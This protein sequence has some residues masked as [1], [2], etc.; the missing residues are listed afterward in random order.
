MKGSNLGE[1]EEIVLLIVGIA[2]EEAYGLAIMELIKEQA[3]RSTTIGAVH[4]VL[5][6]LEDK[7]LLNSKL[8]GATKERGG[9][10][11]RIFEITATGRRALELS[12][13]LRVNL[14]EQYA[15][16]TV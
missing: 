16:K 6:R 12:R 2:G 9:R 8:G 14:W 15:I 13:D 1:F 3:G 11:K 5:S 10:R 7:G 4:A